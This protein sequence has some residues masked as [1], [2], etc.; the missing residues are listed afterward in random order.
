MRIAVNL[1]SITPISKI[2]V[3]SLKCSASKLNRDRSNQ[4]LIK[5]LSSILSARMNSCMEI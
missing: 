4:D 3:I 5:G 2:E 1:F